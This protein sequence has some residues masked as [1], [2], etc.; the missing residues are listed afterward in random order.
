MLVHSTM[1]ADLATHEQATAQAANQAASAHVFDDYRS[2][3]ASSTL[4]AQRYDLAT[5][6]TFLAAVGI[7]RTVEQLQ[8]PAAW[9]TITHGL[10]SAFVQWMLREGYAV[11]SVNRRLSTVKV[12]CDLATKAGGLA[13]QE[14]ALIRL[15]K[16]YDAQEGRRIDERRPRAR[17]STQKVRHTRLT[18]TAAADLMRQPNTPQG[19]RDALLMALLL[20]HG[21]RAGEVAGLRVQDMQIAAGVVTFYRE[22]VHLTQNHRLS[23]NA[24]AAA[25]AYAGDMATDPGAPLLRK[26]R[27]DGSLTDAGLSRMAVSN[28]VRALGE[29]IGIVGLSAHDCRHYWAT[30]A[31]AMGTGIFALKD[32]GGWKHLDMPNRYVDAAA[33][34]N[35]GVKL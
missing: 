10:V 17:L 19:R 5:F 8:Q 27:K 26:S 7:Q 28:R 24:L 34:A 33:I 30:H 21:L 9:Q 29:A 11:A 22:K 25:Q 31:V 13:Q 14:F 35:E 18:A 32:A 1:A 23:S 15:V 4:T 2:R 6:A 16:G 3:K 12:Y 20:D